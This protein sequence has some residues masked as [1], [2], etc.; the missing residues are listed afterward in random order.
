[1]RTGSSPSN[2]F[3][4]SRALSSSYENTKPVGLAGGALAPDCDW[5]RSSP[6]DGV[7]SLAIDPDPCPCCTQIHTLTSLRPHSAHSAAYS[8]QHAAYKTQMRGREGVLRAACTGPRRRRECALACKHALRT[9][10]A[11]ETACRSECP[12]ASG[13]RS[14]VAAC[15]IVK[16]S[17][18][19]VP[20]EFAFRLG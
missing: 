19:N 20:H 17:L 1:V 12:K 14:N 3:L 7:E 15:N 9:H 4:S 8:T 2:C 13:G 16:R 6:A 18:R 11:S 5:D 10:G